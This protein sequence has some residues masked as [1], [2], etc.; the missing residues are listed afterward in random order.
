MHALVRK[1]FSRLHE[2]D[3]E[4]EESKLVVPEAETELELKMSVKAE[5]AVAVGD[6]PA[7]TTTGE[8]G[9]PSD[10]IDPRTESETATPSEI[11]TDIPDTEEGYEQPLSAIST[12]KRPECKTFHF[13]G[14]S[15]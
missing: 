6:T 15:A 5:E 11:A 13:Y 2:L 4:E 8:Q 3:P 10:P 12:A 1:V 7:P 14:Q 9:L